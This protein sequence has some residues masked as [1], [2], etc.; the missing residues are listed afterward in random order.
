MEDTEMKAAIYARKSNDDNDK[1]ADNKSVTRQVERARAYAETKGWLVDDEHIYTDDGIS[2]AEY[3]NRPGFTRLLTRLKEFN[4]IVMSEPSRL[5]RDMLRNAYHIGEILEAGVRIFYYLTNEEEKAE[6]PEQ[7]I[8]L[9]LKGYASEVERQKASQRS[10][11]A[12]ER[13]AQKGHNA[14]GRVYGYDN[15]WTYPDGRREL[16]PRGAKNKPKEAVTEYVINEQEADV[17]RRIYRAYAEGHGV[18]AIAFMLNGDPR[19]AVGAKKH[20][21]GATPPSPWKG[22]G[23]W[24]PS[25]VRA[26]LHNPRYTG[27]IP[28]GK[29]KKAYRKGTKIRIKQS[30]HLT[31]PAPH[32]RIIPDALREEVKARHSAA[33][34][35]YVRNTNGTLWG[36]PGMGAESKYLLTGLARCGCCTANIVVLGRQSG[37]GATRKRV[38]Y[39]GCSYHNNRGRTVCANDHREQMNTVNN[40]VLRAIEEQVL[41][42]TA[43]TYAVETALA[44]I[45][46]RKRAN[47]ERPKTIAAELQK[48]RKELDRL[49]ALVVSG[50]PP[51]K[52]LEEIHTREQRIAVLEEEQGQLLAAREPNELDM[53]NVRKALEQRVGKFKDLLYDHVPLARQ[54]LRK[55]FADPLQMDPVVINGRKTYTFK[56]QTRLGALLDPV[57]LEVASPRGFEPRLPP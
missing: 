15:V 18:K 6:T 19:G 1:D 21:D 46:Q 26:I 29:H 36:R 2:G 12:L 55:L 7:K 4:V 40:S 16:A 10:R 45:A 3:Q 22:T 34:K 35:T 37:A 27:V 56:G 50:R 57:Y 38:Y 25:S 28:Y 54:A 24:A 20:F 32:L 31:I 43:L 49:M 41:N 48:L 9:T 13:K 53:R 51:K 42:P 44:D 23:S 39:Y 33:A 47:P 30:E 52:V 5:G 11:D 8:M 17:V 14:G